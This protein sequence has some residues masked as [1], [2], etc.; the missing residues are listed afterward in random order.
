MTDSCSRRHFDVYDS[1]I[2]NRMNTHR[3]LG[4]YSSIS[5]ERVFIDCII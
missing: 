5:Q 2:N 4:G 3:W 1:V